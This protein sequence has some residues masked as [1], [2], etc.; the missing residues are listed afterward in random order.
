M[1]EG[2]TTDVRAIL[3]RLRPEVEDFLIDAVVAPEPGE[4]LLTDLYGMLRYHL[5]WVDPAFLPVQ[6]RGGKML[7]P[8]LCLLCCE[9][10]GASARRA[11][12]AAAAIEL[13]HNFSLIHDDVEDHSDERRGRPTVRALWGDPRAVN[14]GDALFVLSELA[15]LRAPA[16]GVDPV[17]ALILLRELNHSF[18]AV[19]EGQHLDLTLEG[20]PNVTRD[21][22][23]AVIGRKTAEL[24]GA[25]A[26][27][28]ALSGGARTERA[29]H[30]HRFGAALGLAF[31][32]QDDILGIWGD[33]DEVGKGIAADVYGHKVTLPVIVA[34][35]RATPEAAA[36][37]RQVYVTPSP[38]PEQVADVQRA[39]V[40]FGGRAVAEAE[41]S[42]QVARAMAE[43]DAAQPEPGPAGDLRVLAQSLIGRTS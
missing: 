2:R 22:Y 7:R 11:V 3:A 17:L 19:A 42:D 12:P 16:N 18:L 33:P 27:L 4:P 8:A 38:A 34:L 35:E 9:A 28:G 31:Q 20:N 5:G 25:A 40:T 6:Q 26:R 24:V 21:Q 23:F 39:L 37:L 1:A 30:F 29:A 36:R 14:A 41:V 10:V 32:I 15:L 43:L 13:F